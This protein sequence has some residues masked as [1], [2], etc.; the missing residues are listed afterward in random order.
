MNVEETKKYKYMK[1]VYKVN[2]N[3]SVKIVVTSITGNIKK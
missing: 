1:V 3:D 2:K